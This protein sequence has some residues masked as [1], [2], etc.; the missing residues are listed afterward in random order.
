MAQPLKAKL[1]TKNIKYYILINNRQWYQISQKET[2]NF[3]S[4][5]SQ[6]RP[7]KCK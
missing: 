6:D 4:V 7:L 2:S 3:R 1:T 5:F